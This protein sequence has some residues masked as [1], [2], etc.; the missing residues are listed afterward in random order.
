MSGADTFGELARYYDPIMDHVDYDR[1][2]AVTTALAE[3]LPPHFLHADAGC[4]TG[5][6]LQHLRKIGWR[7]VGVD[8]SHAMLKTARKKYPDLPVAQ[9]DL[10][11]LPLRNLHYVTCLFDTVNFLTELAELQ[12][13][14]RQ[15]YGTLQPGG[16][17]YFDVVTERM[18]TEHFHNQT[19]TEDNGHFRTTWTSTFDRETGIT[20]THVRVNTGSE[21]HINE[22]VYP[23]QVILRAIQNAGFTLLDCVDAF[24]WRSPSRGSTRLDFVAAKQPAPGTVRNFKFVRAKIQQ[25]LQ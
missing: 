18:V 8:L 25:A 21:A 22:R 12:E 23:T 3:L 2:L 11:A 5:L 9:A 15:F 13:A 7:S 17:L 14:L 4:G 10:R 19:W 6:L 16:L 1:W 20:E 24:T